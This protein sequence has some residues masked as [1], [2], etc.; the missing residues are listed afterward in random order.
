MGPG[1]R[2]GATGAPTAIR[3]VL[4]FCETALRWQWLALPTMSSRLLR[5]DEGAGFATASYSH[6]DRFLPLLRGRAMNRRER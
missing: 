6:I 4:V 1:A 5:S 3:H 2:L